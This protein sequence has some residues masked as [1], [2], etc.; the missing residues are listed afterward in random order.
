MP[1]YRAPSDCTLVFDLGRV[2]LDY[3]ELIM[4]RRF[5]SESGYLPKESTFSDQV[6]QQVFRRDL[7]SQLESGQIS[8]ENFFKEICSLAQVSISFERFVD[9]WCDMFTGLTPAVSTLR[10]LRKE[11][12][13][14]YMLSNIDL[15][16]HQYVEK[17]FDIFGFFDRVFLSY[18]MGLVKPDIKIYQEIIKE[19]GQPPENIFFVDDRHEN[20]EGARASGIHSVQFTG[21]DQLEKDLTSFG[22]NG[23]SA[24]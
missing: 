4:A 6:F 19:T 23:F 14:L 16:H 15:L 7:L 22:V 18:Q 2:L 1:S 20:V 9:I 8:P 17:H 3:D 21:V 10:H 13:P 24:T 11:G 5:I 12:Y